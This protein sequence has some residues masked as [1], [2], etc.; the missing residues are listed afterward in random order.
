MSTLRDCLVDIANSFEI[1]Y[2]AQT[3]PFALFVQYASS[4]CFAQYHLSNEP[5]SSN[6][7]VVCRLDSIEFE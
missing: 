3:T 4:E 5:A 2:W 1:H 6:F 7:V